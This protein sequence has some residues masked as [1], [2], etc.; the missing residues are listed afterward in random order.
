MNAM[1]HFLGQ[2]FRS[3]DIVEL[4]AIMN[5]GTVVSGRF[6]DLDRMVDVATDVDTWTETSGVYFCINPL[7]PAHASRVG[8][9][10]ANAIKAKARTTRDADVLIR[11]LYLLDFDPERPKGVCSTEDEKEAAYD[12]LQGV[13][14]VLRMANFPEPVIV[15]SGNGYHAYFLESGND[16][17]RDDWPF[18]LKYLSDT[19]SKEDVKIDAVVGNAARVSRLPGTRNRKGPDTP[20][21]P[22][23]RCK[24]VS[25]PNRWEPMPNGAV[26]NLASN[27]GYLTPEERVFGRG[28]NPNSSLRD[29]GL[30]LLEQFIEESEGELDIGAVRER[31]DGTY[32][33]IVCCPFNGPHR[34][35]LGKTSI[36][37][38][39]TCV[40]FS[41]FSDDCAGLTFAD[42]R[43]QLERLTGHRSTIDFY[44]R[45]AIEDDKA[46]WRAMWKWELDDRYFWEFFDDDDEEEEDDDEEEEEPMPW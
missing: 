17:R 25:Y 22:H 33:D 36:I 14:A 24:V 2:V 21:R 6:T 38:S 32:F 11:R 12:L 28:S 3:G 7:D 37:L 20:E 45:T 39:D 16:P 10:H 15:D 30:D 9:F 23:R 4:R 31:S 44:E 29:D 13:V 5:D 40:G 46:F 18:V 8:H 41:C 19:Y 1:R 34:G 35:A 27:N 26:F 43:D 42:L